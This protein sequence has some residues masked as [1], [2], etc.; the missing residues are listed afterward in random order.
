MGKN[1]IESGRTSSRLRRY[2]RAT[3]GLGAIGAV[4]IMIL[5]PLAAAGAAHP[6]ASKTSWVPN[7]GWSSSGCGK[8][9]SPKP[10]FKPG[11]LVGKWS[12]SASASSCSKPVSGI[13]TSSYDSASGGMEVFL[14]VTLSGATSG[15]NVT[16]NLLVAYDTKAATFNAASC[17][18]VRSGNYSY[19][20]TYLSSWV[21]TT[22]WYSDCSASASADI[23]GSAYIYDVTSGASYYPSNYW[24]GAYKSYDAYNDSS[25]SLT[26][27]SN[28][29]DWANNYSYSSSYGYRNGGAGSGVIG[30]SNSPTWFIN[31]TFSST[32]RYVVVAQISNSVSASI[33]GLKGAGATTSAAINAGGLTNYE[34]LKVT[35]W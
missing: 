9:V 31:S 4:L 20:Y 7:Y 16:W 5:S 15:V 10:I 2:A 1:G 34:D 12:G 22:D 29:A 27:Y 8:V 23:Y 17:P 28:P 21:N 14:P 24:S 19:Y 11:T 3:A 35:V 6:A 18:L 32:D 25:A 26:T 30:A 13:G 33:Y